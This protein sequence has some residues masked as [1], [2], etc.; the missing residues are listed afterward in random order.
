[1]KPRSLPKTVAP[2][3]DELLSG[4]LSRLAAANYCN[5]A[6][7]LAHIEIDTTHGTALD[8]SIDAAAAEKIGNAARV[9]PDVVRSLAFPAM[10]P[11]EASLTPRCHSSIVCNA[12]RGPFAQALEA[13]LGIRLSSLR[14]ETCADTW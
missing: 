11:R 7:L 3:P 2:L 1:M 14:D 9:A 6:E 10:T 5:D 13:G 4:W 12:P 8:F